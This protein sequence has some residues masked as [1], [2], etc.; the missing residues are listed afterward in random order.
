MN[1]LSSSQ[2]K[3]L[4][5]DG[6]LV[7]ERNIDYHQLILARKAA[8]RIKK[9]CIKIGYPYCRADNRLSDR[10]IEKIDNIFC[11]DLFDK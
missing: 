8:D 2:L 3:K 10:F 4:N 7:V 6:Y 11:P 1:K 5:N 9:K